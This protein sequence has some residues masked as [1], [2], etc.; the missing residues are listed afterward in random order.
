MSVSPKIMRKKRIDTLLNK[1]SATCNEGLAMNAKRKGAKFCQEYKR[2]GLD[3]F[4][5]GDSKVSAHWMD[6]YSLIKGILKVG[7]LNFPSHTW[8]VNLFVNFMKK[9]NQSKV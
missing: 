7:W 4:T 9:W 5:Q 2:K 3:H 1:S 8:E 6:Q